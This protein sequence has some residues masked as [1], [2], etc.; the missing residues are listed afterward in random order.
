MKMGSKAPQKVKP[1]LRHV[2]ALLGKGSSAEQIDAM[3][4]KLEAAGAVWFIGDE[5]IYGRK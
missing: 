5:V 2:S 4:A 1:F 3:V